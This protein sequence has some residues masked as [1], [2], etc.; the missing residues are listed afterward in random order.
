M[1]E[2]HWLF[3]P[4]PFY[5]DQKSCGLLC[6]MCT[7]I[8]VNYDNESH[9]LKKGRNGCKVKDAGNFSHTFVASWY[10]VCFYKAQVKYQN[11]SMA[12]KQSW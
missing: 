11:T 3:L 5:N 9:D 2:G 7:Q 12:Q 4:T 6:K 8:F 1:D 10:I